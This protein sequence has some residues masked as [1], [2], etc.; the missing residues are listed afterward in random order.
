[1]KILFYL[2]IVIGGCRSL[3]VSIFSNDI[4]VLSLV[5]LIPCFC[6]FMCPLSVAGAE[7]GRY[8]WP[9]R[10]VNRGHVDFYFFIDFR[11]VCLGVLNDAWWRYLMSDALYFMAFALY[12]MC[13][14]LNVCVYGDVLLY[15]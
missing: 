13:F 11:S 15:S 6:L 8:F 1:M 9:A 12:D 2:S 5:L 7:S 14:V 3:L 4:L 10:D